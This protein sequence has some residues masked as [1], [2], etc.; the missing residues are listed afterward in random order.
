MTELHQIT[1]DSQ[2]ETQDK[3]PAFLTIGFRPFFF[4]GSLYAAIAIVIWII[5]YR[6]GYQNQIYHTSLNWHAHE[7]LFGFATAIIAGFLLTAVRAWTNHKTARGIPL[8]A[9]T[10][11]WIT[12][13]ILSLVPISNLQLPIAIIDILF[14]PCLTLLIARPLLAA[15]NKR[16]YIMPIVL[17]MM[18]AA[19]IAFHLQV[20]G[21]TLN[22]ARPAL[23]LMLQ[24]ILLLMVIIGGRVIPFFT[25]RAIPD[26]RTKKNNL[27]DAL[28][29]A[30][31]LILI[32]SD[33]SPTPASIA[34]TLSLASAFIHLLR[35]IYWYDK[36]IWSN[37]LIW[38]LHVGYVWVP[39][40]FALDAY[41]SLSNINQSLSWHAWTVGSIGTLT[42]GIMARASLGHSGRPLKLSRL[43]VVI[44]ILITAAA[45]IR[46]IPPVFI[47]SQYIRFIELS[48]VLWFLAFLL[49]AITHARIYLSHRPDG[50]ID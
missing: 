41:A 38:V 19:N 3:T 30:S 33:L 26:A 20:L 23:T 46:V 4:L 27:I 18:T 10:I 16:N 24:L 2:A 12:P 28:S 14:I 11:L 34:I 50:K 44:F 42:L 15:G 49:F 37:P 31:I 32:L 17:I 8:L 39:I 1:V 35:M 7:M 29:I 45:C 22:T 6:T 9:L 40:G 48:S 25:T 21:I 47:P 36:R 43:T 13:R 5:A